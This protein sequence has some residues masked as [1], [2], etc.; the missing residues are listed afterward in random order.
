MKE[1]LVR[2]G[3]FRDWSDGTIKAVYQGID[4]IIETTL[5]KNK[6]ERDIDVYCVPTHHYCNLG[7]KMCHLTKEGYSQPMKPLSADSLIESVIRTAHSSEGNKRTEN[8]LG[9]LSFMGVGDPLLNFGMIKEVFEREEEIKEACEYEDITYALSTMMPLG[10]GSRV[11]FE[12]KERRAYDL[13]E[14]R[15]YVFMEGMP[16]KIHFSLHNPIDNERKELIPA[17]ESTVKSCLKTFVNLKIG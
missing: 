13:N 10:F 2:K 14:I 12:Q 3:V 1:K 6:V 7:C 16:L 5:L 11:L 8:K 4:G 9:W 15:D 17:A